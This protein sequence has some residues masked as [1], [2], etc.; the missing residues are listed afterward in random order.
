MEAKIINTYLPF[1]LKLM[2]F[3]SKK[4]FPTNTLSW[5]TVDQLFVGRGNLPQDS[6]GR[7]FSV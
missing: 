4:S 5:T 2:I 1:K 6:Q 7:Q 3:Y